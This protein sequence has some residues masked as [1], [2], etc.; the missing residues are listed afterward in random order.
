MTVPIII[1]DLKTIS[2]KRDRVSLSV[3]W[4][5]TCMLLSTELPC[6]QLV[7]VHERHSVLTGNSDYCLYLKKCWSTGGFFIIPVWIVDLMSDLSY[8]SVWSRVHENKKK[9]RFPYSSIKVTKLCFLLQFIYVA[10]VLWQT[11]LC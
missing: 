8:I 1:I 10:S 7:S 2:S 11:V 9:T 5:A 6:R 4:T 3:V